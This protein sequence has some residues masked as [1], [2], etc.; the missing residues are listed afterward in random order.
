MKKLMPKIEGGLLTGL[1]IA[2]ADEGETLALQDAAI[3]AWRKKTP[4]NLQTDFDEVKLRASIPTHYGVPHGCMDLEVPEHNQDADLVRLVDG[5]LVVEVDAKKRMRDAEKA[6]EA[7]AQEDAEAAQRA[8]DD[9]PDKVQE[10]LTA[11]VR[12]ELDK[13]ARA[14][15]YDSMLSMVSYTTSSVKRFAAEAVAA[16]AW[17]DAVW[18]AVNKVVQAVKA[19]KQAGPTAAELAALLPAANWPKF[20]KEN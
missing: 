15:G 17:R 19:G 16:V 1:E 6:A 12:A 3:A 7:K 13:Q 8:I 2:W 5:N 14:L 11:A 4:E 18:L 10:R 20:S 9:A